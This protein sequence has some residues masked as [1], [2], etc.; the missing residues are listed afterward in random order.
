MR[1]LDERILESTPLILA[2]A[3]LFGGA[4]ALVFGLIALVMEGI[5]TLSEQAIWAGLAAGGG[6]LVMALIA[7]YR[8]RDE[9]KGRKH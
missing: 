4:F 5:F 6:F 1:E 7:R 8:M 2:M 3:S 9:R